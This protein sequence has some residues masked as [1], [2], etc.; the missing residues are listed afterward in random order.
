M[1]VGKKTGKEDKAIHHF[2]KYNVKC[3]IG[4]PA[5]TDITKC[6]SRYQYLITLRWVHHPLKDVP[7]KSEHKIVPTTTNIL[8]NIPYF[9][10]QDQ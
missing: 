4:K 9:H 2:V 3:F 5:L 6:F 7:E 1:A 10:F 8:L